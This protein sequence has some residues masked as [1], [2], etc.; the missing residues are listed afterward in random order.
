LKEIDP[1]QKREGSLAFEAIVLR[2]A[3]GRQAAGFAA[4]ADPVL[5]LGRDDR[6]RIIGNKKSVQFSKTYVKQKIF[7]KSMRAGK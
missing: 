5:E 1:D 7:E 4:I 6:E 3:L 2:E